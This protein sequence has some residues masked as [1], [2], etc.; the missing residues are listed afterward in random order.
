VPIPLLW[1]WKKRFF[2]LPKPLRVQTDG[3]TEVRLIRPI[4][5]A[6]ACFFFAINAAIPM[7]N[8]AFAKGKEQS[9]KIQ[10][11]I[12]KSKTAKKDKPAIDR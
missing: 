7:A 6:L 5:I 11:K 1:W 2:L 8:D 10:H 9:N 3:P 4:V 12:D